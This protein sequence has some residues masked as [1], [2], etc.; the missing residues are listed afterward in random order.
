MDT[1]SKIVA[2]PEALAQIEAR[3]GRGEALRV[4]TGHFDPL[5]GAHARRLEEI[6]ASDGRPLVVI[7]EPDHPLLSAEAR[8]VLV[9][10]LDAV[11]LVTIA[12]PEGLDQLIVR[13]PRGRLLRGEEEDLR[14]RAEFIR[15]VCE[16]HRTG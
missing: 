8:A 9:A 16:R 3:L 10:A 5:L 14:L 15:L 1:R 4:V 2:F 6:A 11:E 13:V 12:P 7:T